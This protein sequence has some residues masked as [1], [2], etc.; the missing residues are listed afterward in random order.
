MA[1]QAEIDEIRNRTDEPAATSAYSDEMISGWI[2]VDENLEKT[3]SRIWEYKAAKYAAL[4]NT[5]ESGSSRA[6]SDLMKNA[7]AMARQPSGD[8]DV[9][10]YSRPS[11]TTPIVRP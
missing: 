10:P 9:P 2:D 1:T 8:P 3:A 6:L 11:Y 7:L 4:V 5:T